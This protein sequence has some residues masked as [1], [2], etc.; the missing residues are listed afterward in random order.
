MNMF[1]IIDPCNEGFYYDF[2]KEDFTMLINEQCFLPTRKMAEEFVKNELGDG[3]EVIEVRI[4]SYRD[5]VM[6]YSTDEQKFFGD[7]D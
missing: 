5:G 4:D 1:A 2:E 6:S 3:C 7:E